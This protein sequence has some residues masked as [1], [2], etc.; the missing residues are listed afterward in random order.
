V[1]ILVEYA[2]VR[3]VEILADSV[4]Y[5]V[6]AVEGGV[7]LAVGSPEGGTPV[8]RKIW[9]VATGLDI[10]IEAQNGEFVNTIVLSQ[11][12]GDK[13]VR[14]LHAVFVENQEQAITRWQHRGIP[15]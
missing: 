12:L 11:Q 15:R 2:S 7:A 10:T 4:I 6:E 1:T 8:K 5:G 3:E 13:T 9:M 14:V